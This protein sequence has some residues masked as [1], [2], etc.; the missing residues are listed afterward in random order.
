MLSV[1]EK[2]EIK[3]KYALDE[4][5]SGSAQ[6][7]AAL[8]TARLDQLQGHFETHLKD[9]HSR[10]GLMKLVG[11]RRR[12]LDYVKRT[13]IQAYRNLIEKLDIRK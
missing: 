8:I 9:H 11:K 13:D 7:Q 2:A 5:D 10:L 1:E 12:L 4:K 3:K 6:L